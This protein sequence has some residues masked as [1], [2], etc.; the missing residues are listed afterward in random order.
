MLTISYENMKWIIRDKFVK[1][2]KIDV[3]WDNRINISHYFSHLN[4]Q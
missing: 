3:N 2:C 4:A 1:L